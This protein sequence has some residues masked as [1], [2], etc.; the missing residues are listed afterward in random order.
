MKSIEEGLSLTI[1][2]CIVISLVIILSSLL[3]QIKMERRLI[4]QKILDSME[5]LI[6]EELIDGG[7]I[8]LH[9][10]QD[11]KEKIILLNNHLN[12]GR[13]YLIKKYKDKVIFNE[14]KEI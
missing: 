5:R 13:T 11:T 12:P 3:G 1:W 6:K 7:W 2:T 9:I 8:T 10:P 14:I 4:I